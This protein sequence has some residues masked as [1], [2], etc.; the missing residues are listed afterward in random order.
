MFDR[1]GDVLHT[2]HTLSIPHLKR[3]MLSRDL[4][5][6]LSHH[7]CIRLT[8]CCHSVKRFAVASPRG[9]SFAIHVE[10]ALLPS[11]PPRLSE[12][13]ACNISFSSSHPINPPQ[14]L[15][16]TNQGKPQKQPARC[17]QGEVSRS[18]QMSKCGAEKSVSITLD[19]CTQLLLCLSPNQKSR[20][21]F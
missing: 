19:L 16:E 6:F 4:P 18:F 7:Y 10:E 11:A 3:L 8:S 12:G 15:A 2:I 14:S 20:S 17:P 1:F 13:E 21:K 5:P 9:A